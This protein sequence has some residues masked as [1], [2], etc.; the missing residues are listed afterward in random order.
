MKIIL[1]QGIPRSSASL[2]RSFG[3]D[4]VHTGE[5]GLSTA[6]DAEI[7]EQGRTQGR[8]VVTL[9]SD[10]HTIV[11]LSGAIEPSVIRIRIEGLRAAEMTRIIIQT[12][13]ICEQD[14]INGA[15][16]SVENERVRLRQ[17]PITREPWR[18]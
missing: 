15:I 9:D 3:F 8:I 2:L 5:V 11:A 13:K 12:I 18:D 10:F 4:A 1:D 6:T 17:L 7:L 14:L 16:V